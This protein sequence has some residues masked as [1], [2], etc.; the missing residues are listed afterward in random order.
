MARSAAAS[1][2]HVPVAKTGQVMFIDIREPHTEKL[3]FKYDPAR[4]LVEIQRQNIKTVVDLTQYKAFRSAEGAQDERLQS[5]IH[6]T[7][8]DTG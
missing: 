2:W 6:D 8:R 7:G 4:E 3:L 1:G 5:A